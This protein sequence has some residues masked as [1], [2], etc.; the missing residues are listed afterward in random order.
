MQLSCELSVPANV[1]G[2]LKMMFALINPS[3]TV[4]QSGRRELM[5]PASGVDYRPTFSMPVAEGRYRLR[6]AVADAQGNIGSLDAIVT[7]EL[8]TL[9]DLKTS[10]LL[11]AWAGADGAPRFAALEAL[12]GDVGRL[13]VILEIY[14]DSR[15][16]M[17]TSLRFSLSKSDVAGG[18]LP[19]DVIAQ[20]ERPLTESGENRSAMADFAMGDLAAGTYYLH[21]TVLDRNVPLGTVSR[22]IIK[23]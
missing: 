14:P 9:G 10:D 18:G 11:M 7:A 21:A 22:R 19:T 12:P 3:G 23:R 15:R 1:A 6:V 4:M 20:T 16:A 13:Q 17:P 2:P 5:P 8:Q